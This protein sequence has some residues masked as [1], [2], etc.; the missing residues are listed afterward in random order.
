[1]SKRAAFDDRDGKF[2]FPGSPQYITLTE[3]N[4]EAILGKYHLPPDQKLICILGP[5]KKFYKRTKRILK[6]LCEHARASGYH[7]VYKTRKKDRVNPY[8]WWLLRGFSCFYDA[9]YHPHTTLE[10][11]FVSNLAV[12]FDSSGIQDIIMA[13]KP[14]INFY[15]K[16]Y[17]KEKDIYGD[18]LIPDLDLSSTKQEIE[19][20]MDRLLEADPR[21]EYRE[22]KLRLYTDESK[23][24]E[25]YEALEKKI[26]VQ[27]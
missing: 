26:F 23:I 22:L 17:R 8:I 9:S 16:S 1:M 10:L 27:D 7:V 2:L 25:N 11:L 3:L 12:N 21:K 5:K 4:R 20:T 6:S 15:T 18:A 14:V 13:E 19:S 24:A